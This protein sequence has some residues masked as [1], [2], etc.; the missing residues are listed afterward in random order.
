MVCVN[1]EKMNKSVVVTLMVC[2]PLAM[3]C[4]PCGPISL[5]PRLSVVSICVRCVCEC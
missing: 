2:R 4:A 1:V 3:C 5:T